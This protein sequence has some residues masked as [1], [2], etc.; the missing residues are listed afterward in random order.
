[1]TQWWGATNS[2]EFQSHPL[3]NFSYLQ[4]SWHNLTTNI[5][6]QASGGYIGSVGIYSTAQQPLWSKILGSIRPS[7]FLLPFRQ[8]E[9]LG[10]PRYEE[11]LSRQKQGVLQ[12]GNPKDNKW[13]PE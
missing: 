2:T 12:I 11:K 8:G 13:P 5:D 7:F 1:M 9:K 3:A 4:K 6:W 10:V